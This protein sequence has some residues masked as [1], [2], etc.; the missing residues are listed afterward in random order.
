M[1]RHKKLTPEERAT[2]DAKRQRRTE[3]AEAEAREALAAILKQDRKCEPQSEF[4]TGDQPV[5]N[6]GKTE[7][8]ELY[9]PPTP[10]RAMLLK[11]EL[12][13]PETGQLEIESERIGADAVHRYN[14]LVRDAAS[15]Q[16]YAASES[17]L[18]DCTGRAS[19]ANRP[20]C[21]SSAV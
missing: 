1:K 6:L 20:R 3:P 13:K 18:D 8:L 7:R 19:R 15:Q 4:V 12:N 10:N 21:I 16:V 5:L 14:V 2:R 9:Y 17:V 11:S